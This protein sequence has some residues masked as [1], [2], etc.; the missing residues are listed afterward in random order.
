M[1]DLTLKSVK[2]I[3]PKIQI[4]HTPQ[5]NNATSVLR[6]EAGVKRHEDGL[7]AQRSSSEAAINNT[8][9]FIGRDLS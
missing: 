9:G 4:R 8:A 3:E 7:S 2:R 5:R 1:S 6:N